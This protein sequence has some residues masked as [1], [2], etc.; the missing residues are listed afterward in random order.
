MPSLRRSLILYFV[1]LLAIG[2]GTVALLADQVIGNALADKEVVTAKLIDR[3]TVDRVDEESK[4]FEN[5]LLGHARVVARTAGIEYIARM[6]AAN[7]RFAILQDAPTVGLMV[8][9]LME[10]TWSTVAT[11]KLATQTPAPRRGSG[12]HVNNL[13]QHNYANL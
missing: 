7:K 1:L 11:W 10:P 5:E 2:L 9:G 3:T 8:S 12:P 4:R 13:I 6:D